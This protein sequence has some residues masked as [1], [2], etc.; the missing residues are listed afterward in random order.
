MLSLGAGWPACWSGPQ[1]PGTQHR[2]RVSA[3]WRSGAAHRP[4]TEGGYSPQGNR[5]GSHRVAVTFGQEP[6]MQPPFKSWRGPP[7]S[8]SGEG[9]SARGAERQPHSLSEGI[10]ASKL[11]PG[12]EREEPEDRAPRAADPGSG[13][14]WAG[15]QDHRLGQDQAVGAPSAGGT[16]ARG[17]Q[18]AWIRH[19]L[20]VCNQES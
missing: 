17:P 4:E 8:G 18:S 19:L 16:K 5:S 6:G 7:C 20:S 14:G 9:H 1:Q 3:V 11:V 10:G 15:S 2:C 13:G 12:S